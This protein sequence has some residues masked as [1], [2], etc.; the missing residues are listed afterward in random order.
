[1]SGGWSLMLVLAPA[2]EG[3][4]LIGTVFRCAI[5]AA[6]SV[7]LAVFG[8]RNFFEQFLEI[9]PL[10]PHVERRHRRVLAQVL[11][12]GANGRANG[13]LAM[14]RFGARGTSREFYTHDQAHEV[15]FPGS[16]EGFVE[17]IDVENQ[18]ALRRRERSEIHDV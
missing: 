10:I 14:P 12:I 4:R 11:A 18:V 2:V 9:D 7:A 6:L 15:P 17:I 8:S 3:S 13:V 5:S 1:M 16:G